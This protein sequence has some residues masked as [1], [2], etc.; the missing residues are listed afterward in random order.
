MLHPSK[1]TTS[2]YG[3]ISC[4]PQYQAETSLNY[5]DSSQFRARITLQLIVSELLDYPGRTSRSWRVRAGHGCD[6]YWLLQIVSE[7]LQARVCSEMIR[8]SLAPSVETAIMCKSIPPKCMC[9]LRESMIVL[10]LNSRICASL[11][12]NTNA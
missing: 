5:H 10:E 9:W 11:A 3:A 4:P 7:L 6:N 2:L 1:P 8:S 12:L